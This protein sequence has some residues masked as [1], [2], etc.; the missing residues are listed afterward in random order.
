[1]DWLVNLAILGA[2]FAILCDC[3]EILPYFVAGCF[4]FGLT[5]GRKNSQRGDVSPRYTEQ[6]SKAEIES[7]SQEIIKRELN[8]DAPSY[9]EI[10]SVGAIGFSFYYLCYTRNYET[11]TTTAKSDIVRTLS[12]NDLLRDLKLFLVYTPSFIKVLIIKIHSNKE[13]LILF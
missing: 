3:G 13:M 12:K 6:R 7:D 10:K 8:R 11:L 2:S 4:V 5:R 1:M 9:E